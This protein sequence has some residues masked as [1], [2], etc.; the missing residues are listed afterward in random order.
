MGTRIHDGELVSPFESLGRYF[1]RGGT[2][3][4]QAAFEHSYFVHPDRVREKTPLYPDRA[5]CS[6]EYYPKRNRGD[7]ATWEG[8]EVRLGD[9][10]AAQ[11]A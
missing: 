10:S 1:E 3:V 6:R 2:T 11:R 4:F 9:N 5:R 7:R 8:R